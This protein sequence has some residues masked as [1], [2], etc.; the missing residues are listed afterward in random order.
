MTPNCEAMLSALFMND[1][2]NRR[3]HPDGWQPA[4]IRDPRQ[5]QARL[6][7]VAGEKYSYRELDDYTELIQRTLQG[8]PQVSRISRAGV[9]PEQVNL[10][11]SQQRLAQYGYIPSNLKDILAAQNITLPAGTIEAGSKDININPRG[12]FPMRRLSAM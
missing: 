6:T 4:F 3:L 2:I 11:Y 12:Y 7:A 5:T 10:V 9:L 1:C 8:A